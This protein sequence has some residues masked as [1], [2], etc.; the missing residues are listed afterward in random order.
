MNQPT[1][2]IALFLAL[3]MLV[4]L[5]RASSR[6]YYQIQI[7]KLNGKLQEE[8]T[9]RFLK[10]AYLPALHRAGIQKVGVFKP[11]ESDTTSGKRIYVWI[12]FYRSNNLKKLEKC[13][14]AIRNI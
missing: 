2:R 5:C 11:V 12:P 7:F 14:P 3:F 1:T 6:D 4:S 8:K 13:W 10:E 9:D